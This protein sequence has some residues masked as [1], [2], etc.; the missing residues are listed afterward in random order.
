MSKGLIR[1]KSPPKLVKTR[2]LVERWNVSDETVRRICKKHN[3]RSF[4]VGT[5][6][7]SPI[8]WHLTDIEKVE[9]TIFG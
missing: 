5:S 3:V 2:T 9:E 6:P 7:G 8:Q 4:R 1:R